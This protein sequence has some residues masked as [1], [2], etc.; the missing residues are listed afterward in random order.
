MIGLNPIY[1]QKQFFF[2]DKG[3]QLTF[4]EEKLK[5]S[6]C[7]YHIVMCHPPLIAHNPQRTPDMAPYIVREQDARLQRIIDQNKNVIFLSG[8]THVVPEIEFLITVQKQLIRH[9]N[10]RIRRINYCLRIC[11]RM[12]QNDSVEKLKCGG[13]GM[14]SKLM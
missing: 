8:H 4:L 1:H 7:N 12:K 11:T 5:K 10:V 6:A 13:T 3:K 14:I 9:R 2:Q